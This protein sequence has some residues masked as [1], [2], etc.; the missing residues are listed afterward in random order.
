MVTAWKTSMKIKYAP[1]QIVVQNEELF[2]STA[3]HREIDF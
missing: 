2:Q 1:I 3:E